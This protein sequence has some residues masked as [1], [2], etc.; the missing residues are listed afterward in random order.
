MPCC[1]VLRPVQTKAETEDN[2]SI[3]ST[4]VIALLAISFIVPMVQYYAYTARD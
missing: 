2:K 1:A 4:V 3:T